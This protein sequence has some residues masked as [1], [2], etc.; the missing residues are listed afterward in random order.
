MT[1]EI[2]I[3]EINTR[4]ELNDSNEPLGME[5]YYKGYRHALE[6]VLELIDLEV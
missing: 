4:L 1:K 6:W 2:L 5:K 3:H